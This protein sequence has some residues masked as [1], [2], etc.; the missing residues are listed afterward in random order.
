AV[1]LGGVRT[2]RLLLGLFGVFAAAAV[3]VTAL[4]R[5]PVL[6]IVAVLICIGPMLVWIRAL[7]RP[8][9]VRGKMESAVRAVLIARFLSLIP[10]L[11]I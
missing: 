6:Y 9:A 2:R 4:S 7:L 5:M 1:G 8:P 3:G 11:L 10:I